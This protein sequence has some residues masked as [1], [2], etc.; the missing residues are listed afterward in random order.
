MAD[1]HG[2]AIRLRACF[3]VIPLLALILAGLACQ[4]AVETLP[5]PTLLPAVPAEAQAS[6]GAETFSA[7]TPSVEPQAGVETAVVVAVI[8]GDTIDVAMGGR[9]YRV[10]Y[11][12]INTPEYDEVCYWEA[13]DANAALV[14]GQMVTMYRDVSET[15]RYGR[16][17]RYVYAGDTFVNAELVAEG[18]AEAVEYPPDT[19]Y[20][21]YL[22]ELEDTARAAGLGCWPTGVFGDDR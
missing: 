19:A 5:P 20:A 22:E 18:W 14:E 15:D 1:R 7:S 16:L 8:D 3:G 2:T 4:P 10:R 6:G 17:L 13:T 21:D 9:T 12:G 11:I